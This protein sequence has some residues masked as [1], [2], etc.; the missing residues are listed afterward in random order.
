MRHA[1]I[2]SVGSRVTTFNTLHS[3]KTL[4]TVLVK[5][6][7]LISINKSHTSEQLLDWGFLHYLLVILLLLLLLQLQLLLLLLLLLTGGVI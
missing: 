2:K 6:L 3:E 1:Q 4:N 7:H 5:L